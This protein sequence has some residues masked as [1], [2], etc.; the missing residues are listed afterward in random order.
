ME[1]MTRVDTL[2]A[3]TLAHDLA[4][5]SERDAQDAADRAMAEAAALDAQGRKRTAAVLR[6]AV[7]CLGAAWGSEP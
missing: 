3:M 2:S 5:G 6:D 1:T 4:Q 7:R